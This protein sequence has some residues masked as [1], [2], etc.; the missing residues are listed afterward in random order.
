MASDDVQKVREQMNKALTKAGYLTDHGSYIAP[1]AEVRAIADVR[2]PGS[3][4][5]LTID[6][7]PRKEAG[8][9]GR[10]LVEKMKEVLDG[11]D[12]VRV[13][14]NGLCPQF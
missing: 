10:D 3:S 8:D 5:P 14:P 13:C 12:D 2:A 7:Y 4:L 1:S 11:I 9:A 6:V